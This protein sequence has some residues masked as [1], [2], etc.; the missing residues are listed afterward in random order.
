[1]ISSLRLLIFIVCFILQNLIAQDSM[2]R[3]NSIIE[4]KP[5]S[6][7]IQDTFST[8]EFSQAD[9]LL[10]TK[11]TSTILS[12]PKS[13]NR[14][15]HVSKAQ[16]IESPGNESEYDIVERSIL[17]FLLGTLIAI[18]YFFIRFLLA[19]II[20][21]QNKIRV[22]DFILRIIL[23]RKSY[24]REIYLKSDAWNR[25]RAVVL[26]RDQSVCVYCKGKATEIHHLKYARKIG[27]EPID[28]LVSICRMC[29]DKF[30][31]F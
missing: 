24:Y 17:L 9:T 22:P 5:P 11:S 13:K 20:G 30:H 18:L 3:M 12:R 1:M 26:K 8:T 29:H 10:P 21:N 28:W 23:T 16:Q 27:R 4:E 31:R 25:K 6:N 15:K 7:L 2:D 14:N 19:K